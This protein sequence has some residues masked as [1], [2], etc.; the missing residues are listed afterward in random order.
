MSTLASMRPWRF[1]TDNQGRGGVTIHL[2]VGF[3]EAVA[4]CHG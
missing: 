3:N 2:A 4:F 1:A